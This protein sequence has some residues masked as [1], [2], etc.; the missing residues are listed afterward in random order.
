MSNY[1]NNDKSSYYIHLDLLRIIACFFVIVNHTNSSIFLSC[2]QPSLTWFV[3]LTWFFCCKIAVPLFL[4]ISGSLLLP[5]ESSYPK[6]TL[7]IIRMGIVLVTFSLF[8]YLAALPSLSDIDLWEFCKSVYQNSDINHTYWYLYLYIGILFMLPLLQKLAKSMSEKDYVYY[9]LISYGIVNLIPVFCIFR[10]G[11]QYNTDINLVIFNSYIGML[12]IG[13]Y[14]ERY[15]KIDEKIL[16][17]SIITFGL[18]LSF[19][20]GATYHLFTNMEKKSM[21]Y[22]A[23]DNRTLTTIVIPSACIYIIVKYCCSN[24]SLFQSY[25]VQQKIQELS[26]LT[27]GIYLI[28]EF[29]IQKLK[30]FYTMTSTVIP[31]IP[32]MLLYELLIFI[33]SAAIIY[34]LRKIPVIRRYL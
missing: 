31:K 27:F 10:P 22:L 21:Q 15:V 28:S 23:L 14:I 16:I 29:V 33:C 20:V 9:F 3:S 26:H 8:Y 2:K 5:R 6:T 30:W 13:Y 1:R 7:K 12:F 32:A 24:L 25:R 34:L 17:L 18:I 19:N 4:M 11:L